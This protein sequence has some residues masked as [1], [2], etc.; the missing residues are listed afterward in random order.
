MVYFRLNT[1]RI[2]RGRGTDQEPT[3][4]T[5]SSS[6]HVPHDEETNLFQLG[7]RLPSMYI[8]DEESQVSTPVSPIFLS[9]RLIKG[10]PTDSGPDCIT[11]HSFLRVQYTD[12]ELRK[13]CSP[14][15]LTIAEYLSARISLRHGT[16]IS[17]AF[18]SVACIFNP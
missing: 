11:S 10:S 2:I 18:V 4:N 1:R 13:E 17:G 8:D 3:G 14:T 15:P 16:P 5:A 12:F 7:T 9:S 6:R